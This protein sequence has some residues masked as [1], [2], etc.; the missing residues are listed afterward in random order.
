MVP[1]ARRVTVAPNE[2]LRAVRRP[3]RW[4]VERR[5]VPHDLIEELR[6]LD[7]VRRGA[8]RTVLEGP[9]LWVRNVAAVV[10]AVEVNAVPA[11]IMWC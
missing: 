8:R 5:R 3:I 10:C 9:A 6:D 4:V 7:G 11:A 2:R 1:V